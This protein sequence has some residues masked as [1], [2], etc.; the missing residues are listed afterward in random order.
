M[1]AVY[2]QTAKYATQ[3]HLNIQ[4]I[5]IIYVNNDNP[6]CQV[7]WAHIFEHSNIKI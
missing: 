5:L 3:A 4:Y 6:C 2:T 1:V 7:R